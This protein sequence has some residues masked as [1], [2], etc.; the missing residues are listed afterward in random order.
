MTAPR[1]T[2]L[3]AGAATLLLAGAPAAAQ[4][5][6]AIV[7]N[8]M[9]ECAKI[10]DS[11]ARLACYDSNIRAA[12]GNP[13]ASAPGR[14]TVPNAGVS[15]PVPTSTPQGFGAESVRAPQRAPAPGTAS[16]EQD[17]E[18]SAKIT[19]ISQRG[20]GT[21]A[22]TLE[23]GAQWQFAEGVSSSYRVPR[24]G[25][26]VEIERGSLGSFLMRFDKQQAVQVRRTR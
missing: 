1:A 12:G 20:P 23:G 3:A 16:V 8:I 11:T 14:T 2:I 7:L 26:T 10:G 4:V 15:A 19:G 17:D 13:S 21:Y 25:S 5:D 9:R 22:F 18:I 6:D 24:V